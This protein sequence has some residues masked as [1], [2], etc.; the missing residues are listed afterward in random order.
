L[1]A[2]AALVLLPVSS[3][4]LYLVLGSPL[5]PG[6][7][8]AARVTPQGSPPIAQLVAQV[9]SHLERNPQDGRG[10]EVIAP[11]Y[12]QLGRFD[13]A[14]R[15]FRNAITY[16]GASATREA[17]LGEALA[18][19]A[20]GIVTAEAKQAFERAVALDP[21][22]AKARYF[23]GLSAQQDGRTAE[24]AAMW[25][26]LVASAPADAP[27]AGF[28][29]EELARIGDAAPQAAR[30]PGAEEMAAAGEMNPQQR[31]QMIV[32]MVEGL[33]ER[34]KKDGGDFEGWLRLVRA[35]TVL[36]ERDKAR[37]AAADARRA[38]GGDT[39]KLRRLDELVKGLGLES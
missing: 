34:L 33:A 30:G 15:A 8:F 39:E 37:S 12:L 13:D 10:W 32:G 20:K 22:E 11:V 24:A 9:E 7:P 25:R 6:Q 26:E 36:G 4:A 1:V 14:A 29:R 19:G 35:Y 3:F 23:L 31:Q 17:N 27:W 18:A 5:L 28:V 38:V 16:N 21:R 2:L